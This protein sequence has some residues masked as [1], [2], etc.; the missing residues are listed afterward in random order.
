[1]RIVN[2]ILAIVNRILAA[3][4][5]SLVGWFVIGLPV[6]LIVLPSLAGNPEAS[7][8]WAFL[9][10]GIAVIA[11]IVIVLFAPTARIAWGRLF[12]LN[13]LVSLALP[14][15]GIVS[16]ALL[17]HQIL[18]H[19][20]GSREAETGVAMGA[21]LGGMMVSGMLGIV[22]FFLGAIFLVLAFV[23]LRNAPRSKR[24]SEKLSNPD[25]QV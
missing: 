22:G 9:G 6:M 10:P 24:R 1:M 13:G 11:T 21:G 2:R 3:V 5:M 17:G 15:S 18:R 20:E 16:S 12:L 8:G 7:V 25:N 19:V 23:A 14:L 4:V